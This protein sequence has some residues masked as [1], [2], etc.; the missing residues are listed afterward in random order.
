MNTLKAEKRSMD[1][2]AKKL[3]R[4]GF[5]TGIVFG[6]ELKESI[7]IKI[8]KKEAQKFLSTNNKG[9]EAE[10]E[11]DGKKMVVLVKEVDY[12]PL[13][14]ETIEIDFQALVKGEKVH[15]VAE[16]ILKN[17]DK[18]PGVVEQHLTEVAF[19]ATPDALTDKIEIDAS[20][21]KVGDT[22]KVGDLDIAKNKNVTLQT[23]L[24]QVVVT[25]T[26]VFYEEPVDEDAQPVATPAAPEN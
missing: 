18:V 8:E 21:L 19:K 23:D 7:P 3:R 4:E 17:F 11:L 6:R 24:D 1:V 14:R 13:K 5:V 26:E 15:S 22:V 9:S 2:K 25:V 20:K 10:L 16:I 12:D